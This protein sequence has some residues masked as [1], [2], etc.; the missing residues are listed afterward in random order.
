MAE[1]AS[2]DVAQ[3]LIGVCSAPART[4]I[5]QAAPCVWDC[6]FSGRGRAARAHR[7]AHTRTLYCCSLCFSLP[8]SPL[9]GCA[10]PLFLHSGVLR[11]VA[12]VPPSPLPLFFFFLSPVLFLFC[13]CSGGRGV[14][15]SVEFSKQNGGGGAAAAAGPGALA[16]LLRG[17]GGGEEGGL[18]S[19][20]RRLGMGEGQATVSL[21]SELAPLVGSYGTRLPGRGVTLATSFRDPHQIPFQPSIS[22]EAEAGMEDNSDEEWAQREARGL[23]V[24]R[25]PA[26]RGL[27]EGSSRGAAAGEGEADSSDEEGGPAQQQRRGGAEE[28]EGV[29]GDLH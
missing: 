21:A 8:T 18:S 5:G 15:G 28:D 4:F 23:G 14:E 20:M 19:A 3:R 24:R 22:E 2:Q 7:G 12:F 17:G 16:G 6:F 29:F 26:G 13:S 10:T 11:F 9:T 25:K 1:A 27:V